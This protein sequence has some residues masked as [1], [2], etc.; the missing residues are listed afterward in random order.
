M[1]AIRRKEV[2]MLIESLTINRE[3]LEGLQSEEQEAYDNLPESLQESERGERM[4]EIIGNFESAL[5]SLDELIE[6]LEST[7]EG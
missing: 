5:S 4:S 6:Y 3:V 2:K 7:L 1:N